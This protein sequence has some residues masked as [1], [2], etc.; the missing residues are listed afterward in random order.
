MI[1]NEKIFISLAC[2]RDSEIISTILNAYEKAQLKNNL[3]FGVFIQAEE[4][5]IEINSIPKEINLRLLYKDYRRARGPAYARA[6][7]YDTLYQDEKYYLQIDSH[8]RFVENWDVELI[9]M[10]NSL[11]PNSVIS[12]YPKGYKLGSNKLIRYKKVNVL[13]L[14]KM[15][16]GIPIFTSGLELLDK[17]KRNYFWAAGFS[18]CYGVI[19]KIV[20]FIK[21]CFLGFLIYFKILIFFLN[22]FDFFF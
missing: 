21:G 9:E 22:F 12:T 11:K 7:I 16:E 20:K 19:F 10:L 6:I 14:K 1:N 13:K 15:R 17:P 8:S 3:V 4:G 5:E 18:F 2:Y